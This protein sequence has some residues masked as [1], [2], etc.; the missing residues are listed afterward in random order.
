[1]NSL[2]CR[3]ARAAMGLSL[4]QLSTRVGLSHTAIARLETNHHKAT[5]RC[6]EVLEKYFSDQKIFFGPSSG[7]SVNSN[8]FLESRW[9]VLAALQIAVNHGCGSKEMLS[10][11]KEA[12]RQI[13]LAEIQT[14]ST[15]D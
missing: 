5:I 14:R 13:D 15:A 11:A 10:A 1:V 8:A 4:R 3:M 12:D 7:V 9:L 6:S 2:Q